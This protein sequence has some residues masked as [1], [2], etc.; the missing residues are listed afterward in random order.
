MFAVNLERQM[1]GRDATPAGGDAT[2]LSARSLL[3]AA[4]MAR[5]RAWL[6]RMFGKLGL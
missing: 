5:L 4:L 2:A 6:K 3:G 1:A